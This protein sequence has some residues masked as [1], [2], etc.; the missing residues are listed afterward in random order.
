MGNACGSLKETKS[1]GSDHP[2]P[3]IDKTNGIIRS[4]RLQAPSHFVWRIESYS[5]MLE[6]KLEKIDSASFEVDGYQWRLT[7]CP[8]ADPNPKG[9][10]YISQ[11]LSVL[12]TE[13]LPISWNIFVKF[14]FLVFD[15][16][17]DKYLVIQ[18]VREVSHFQQ[19]K[20]EWGFAHAL[21]LDVFKNPSNGY[22]VNDCCGFGVDLS[23]FKATTRG[24]CFSVV[25]PRTGANSYSFK[26]ENSS[27]K[28][29]EYVESEVFTIEG[30]QWMLRLYPRGNGDKSRVSLY[31]LLVSNLQDCNTEVYA[32]CKVQMTRQHR[33][34]N[35]DCIRSMGTG[36]DILSQCGFSNGRA[37]LIY[38]IPA[39]NTFTWELEGTTNFEVQFIIISNTKHFS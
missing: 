33:I 27:T 36:S 26:I 15:Q 19:T 29:T 17:R 13:D 38:F 9:E 23:V 16:I 37:S 7:F 14:Q 12:N 1:E 18:D 31:L 24:E 25:K 6:S 28:D 10:G 20:T 32:T 4:T 2:L 22:L 39:E 30:I 34:G 3:V 35:I 21:P 11:Y 5:T 8:N